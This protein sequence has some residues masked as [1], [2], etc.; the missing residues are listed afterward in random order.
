MVTVFVDLQAAFASQHVLQVQSWSKVNLAAAFSL[1]NHKG[2]IF[3]WTFTFSWSFSW[4]EKLEA[5]GEQILL[6]L[7]SL[8][9]INESLHFYLSFWKYLVFQF[10]IAG[11][12]AFV[13]LGS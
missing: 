1:V 11:L 4:L 12:F 3:K 10:L 9:I 5:L 8:K 6:C 2:I 7:P 13:N